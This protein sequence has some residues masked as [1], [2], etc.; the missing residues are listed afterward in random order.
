MGAIVGILIQANRKYCQDNDTLERGRPL[1]GFSQL[2][3][4][5]DGQGHEPIQDNP[6]FML[7]SAEH[8]RVVGSLYPES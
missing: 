5:T 4:D 7:N 6:V 3:L 2:N 8:Q 1:S